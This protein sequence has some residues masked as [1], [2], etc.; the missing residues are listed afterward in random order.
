MRND[1][2]IIP[3]PI[4]N[5]IVLEHEQVQPSEIK[6]IGRIIPKNGH[7]VYE[8]NLETNGVYEAQFTKE[9]VMYNEQGSTR[10]T[11]KILAKKNC[12][13]VSAL[14]AKNA[15]RKCKQQMKKLINEA[16]RKENS[17]IPA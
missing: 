14:N 4:V 12:L 7:T 17:G 13:Y 15:V 3:N 11:K 6:H 5:E 2:N 8:I 16:I 10:V 9:A 1:K